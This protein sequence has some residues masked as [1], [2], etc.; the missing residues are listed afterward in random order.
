MRSRPPRYLLS[1]DRRR[2]SRTSLA[3]AAGSRW[4]GVASRRSGGPGRRPWTGSSRS[5]WTT[6]AWT[7]RRSAA[8]SWARPRP[9]AT[10]PGHP[11]IVTVHDAG[12]PGRR[13][14]LSGDEASV[15]AGRSP[16]WLRPE[17]R[18]SPKR[19]CAVGVQ[20]ADALAVVHDQGMLH[21]DVKPPNILIDG[22]GNPGLTDF[23]LSASEP[24][25]SAGLTL[26]FAPPEVLLDQAAH[27]GGGRLPARSDPLRPAV[28]TPAVGGAGAGRLRGCPIGWPVCA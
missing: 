11:G 23:G 5:R 2:R 9:R 21:R 28:R 6:V 15:R 17:N 19:I 1:C 13:P 7:A 24:R 3:S 4:P 27:R 20:I 26:A 25:A 22:Y 10:C 12:H 18:Q 8:G 14:S 16:A